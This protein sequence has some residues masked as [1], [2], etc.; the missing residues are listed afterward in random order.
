MPGM[1]D[2]PTLHLV[3]SRRAASVSFA[4]PDPVTLAFSGRGAA[5]R[6]IAV[7]PGRAVAAPDGS[8]PAEARGRMS[9]P[10]QPA[11]IQAPALREETLARTRLLD[12]LSVKI[13]SRVVFLV[14][15]AGYGKTTLLADF[16][17]RTRLRTIWYRIDEED[18]DWVGFLAHLVAAGREFDPEFAPRT[19]AILRSLEPGGPTR[20]DAIE[21]FLRELPTIT[22]DGAALIL[23]DFHLADE[24]ADI[25]L[26]AREIVAHGPERLSVVFASRRPPAVPVAKLRSLGELAELGIADL[27]FSDSEVEQLFRET[28]HRPLEPDVLAELASRTEGWAASLTLVQAALRERSPAETR[29]F[30]R[31]LSGARDELHDYLA[32]EVVGDLSEMH[33][34]FLMQTS[35]LQR[36]TPEL[37]QVATGMSAIEV[38]SMMSEAER[39]GM[40]GRRSNRRS[41]TQGYHPLVREFLEERL[42]AAVGTQ[43]EAA[44]HLQVA[45]WAEHSDWHSAAFHY[46]AAADWVGV[47]SVIGTH[48]EKIVAS[49]AFAAAAAFIRDLSPDQH[50]AYADVI[51]SRL[52]SVEGDV[53][54]VAELAQRASN[55]DPDNDLVAANLLTARMLEGSMTDALKMAERLSATAGSSLLRDVG[56][57]TVSLLDSSLAGDLRAAASVCEDLAETS[58]R[59]GLDHFE[60]VS[61]LNAALMRRA[62]GNLERARYCAQRSIDALSR[63]SSGRELASAHFVLGSIQAFQGNLFLGRATINAAGAPLRSAA[64]DEYLVEL[65]ELEASLGDSE[66]AE[67]ALAEGPYA[68]PD[69]SAMA[70]ELVG[71]I[72]LLRAGRFDAAARH[73]QGIWTDVP[74]PSPGFQSHRH[75]LEA[76][77]L[78]LAGDPR[79]S[80]KANEATAFASAQGA[81]PWLALATLAAT[82]GTSDFSF[83]IVS[84][85]AEC[86]FV[87]TMG[88]ELLA[89][90]LG[91]LDEAAASVIAE[92]AATAPERWRPALRVEI[93]QKNPSRLAAARLLDEIG[94]ASDILRLRAVAREPR[95]STS[96][97]LL[98][99]RLARRLAHQAHVADLGRVSISIGGTVVGTGDIRRKVLALLCFLLTRPKWTAAREEVM[100]ALWPDADPSA[101]V[102]SLNQTVYFL[103]RVFEAEYSEETTAG[104]VHQDS[105]LV[106]LDRELVTSQSARCMELIATF[107][108]N[109]DPVAAESLAQM[110]G[111]RFALDF[112]YEDW[113]QDFREWL[114][115]AYLHVVETQVRLDMNAGN[116][117]R[118]LSIARRALQVE[119]RNDELELSL[120][121][122]LRGTGSHA[123]AAEQYTRYADVLRDDLG[124]E[125]PGPDAV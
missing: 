66:A 35:I 9:Y 104:Y 115:V 48:A 45:R 70:R 59:G 116:Y 109:R 50:S 4:P 79:A 11:K 125:P 87:L 6:P 103:R 64:R 21:T 55:K 51:L 54:S 94:D 17:R 5:G 105:D 8:V 102:N 2:Q 80:Q 58:E 114:H 90:N 68:S 44:L 19:A 34:R 3:D 41:A 14:A 106:W 20:E 118:G 71:G 61:W 43:G 23:D 98:G 25:R 92:V 88:A 12:W 52:A 84:M 31:G 53:A 33:Q 110:Y 77:A 89:R 117:A 120:L 82:A 107:E 57:A 119:P 62:Q 38:Q 73:L 85:T 99:R 83:A 42:R 91:A 60:G 95:Q 100:D 7:G 113:S 47:E 24:V 76:V 121:R 81:R 40:L 46:A 101:A 29:A 13:H 96:D 26:I 27:R 74:A 30:I 39:L 75:A 97:R 67:R 49:G 108:K 28:Y 37:A 69:A 56:N 86:R 111:G 15:D 36:V 10:I 78:R 122:L 124:V 18:R 63:S 22:G 16:S 65:A 32:E 123:A 72:L 1:P 112:A 93:S